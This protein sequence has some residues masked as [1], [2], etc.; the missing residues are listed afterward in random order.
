MCDKC[1]CRTEHRLA[2]NGVFV[3]QR[4]RVENDRNLTITLIS[5]AS[6]SCLF[7]GEPW[8][9]FLWGGCSLMG[10]VMK[11]LQKEVFGVAELSPTTT[12]SRRIQQ[13][14]A[15]AAQTVVD[16]LG[17][18]KKPQKRDLTIPTLLPFP[19]FHAVP[20][21]STII[22]CLIARKTLSH[23][24]FPFPMPASPSRRPPASLPNIT[25]LRQALDYG[26]PHLARCSAFY[27]D[28]R[29]FR[30]KFV[31]SDGMLGP[32]LHDWRDRDH[33]DG[34]REM[35][36]AYLDRDGNGLLFWPDDPSAANFNDL[37]YTH[38]RQQYVVDSYSL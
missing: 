8:S 26:D 14:S 27:D 9:I 7:Y 13:G 25:A 29:A 32:S 10:H 16:Q 21:I 6:I 36:R 11:N 3:G 2:G 35:T 20:S 5:S 24:H 18:E 23:E 30:K 38:D 37:Q 34:L 19:Q 12:H 1:A 17:Q 33:Q 15:E 31:T 28:V 22:H 4:M